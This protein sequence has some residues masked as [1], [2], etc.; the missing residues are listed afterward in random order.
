MDILYLLKSVPKSTKE[1]IFSYGE[2]A[3]FCVC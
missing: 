2:Q 3:F 1:K